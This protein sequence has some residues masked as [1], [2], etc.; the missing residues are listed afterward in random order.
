MYISFV[1]DFPII[2]A[3]KF[4]YYVGFVS[5]SLVSID[6]YK[7]FLSCPL[8]DMIGE[9]GL[10]LDFNLSGVFWRVLVKDLV[11]V[12]NRLL[13]PVCFG[14]FIFLVL[15]PFVLRLGSSPQKLE[16][17]IA[18]ICLMVDGEEVK[19]E[20]LPFDYLRKQELQPTKYSESM[21]IGCRWNS[22]VVIRLCLSFVYECVIS[23]NAVMEVLLPPY[24]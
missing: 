23:S 22:V 4:R 19:V 8:K 10:C 20:E 18:G 9:E 1:H 17:R 12:V 2:Q 5:Q 11:D 24:V 16:S 13:W 6:I 14:E 3:F 21:A 15:L 7:A